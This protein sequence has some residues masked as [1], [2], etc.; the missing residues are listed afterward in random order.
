MAKNIKK[1]ACLLLTVSMVSTLFV[2]C[3]S[4]GGEKKQKAT[5]QAFDDSTPMELSYMYWEDQ[6]IVNS[7]VEGWNEKHA[8][9][10][11]SA[12]M[13]TTGEINSTIENLVSSNQVPD[14]FWVLGTPEN[15]IKKGLLL[16]MS[17]MWDLDEDAQN[18][19]GGVNDFGL[20]KF[21]TEGKWTTPVKFFPTTMF[22]NLTTFKNTGVDMPSQDWSWEDFEQVVEDNSGTF[23]GNKYF[24]ISEACTVIT[25]YPI[26]SDPDCIGEFGWNGESFDLTNWADGMEL[27][28]SFIQDEYVSPNV[29]GS[30]YGPAGS[31]ADDALL[32]KYYG[33]AIHTQDLGYAAIRVDQWWCWERFW[34]DTTWFDNNT[35]FVPYTVPHTED[36]A[37]STNMFATIDFGAIYSGTPH[38][39]ESYYLLKYMTWGADGWDWKLTHR[40]EIR[41]TAIEAGGGDENNTDGGEVINNCPITADADIWDRYEKMHP[42]AETGDPIEDKLKAAGFNGDERITAFEGFWEKVKGGKWTCYGSQQIPGF[43]TWL[44]GSYFKDE[45]VAGYEGIENGC[46]FGDGEPADFVDQ[47]NESANANADEFKQILKDMIQKTGQ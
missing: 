22:L 34:N 35:F 15:F 18:V 44:N 46:F 28:K 4:D 16:D 20:G 14:V 6:Y 39:L 21:G 27:E 11:L 29:G 42:H 2:G 40:D 12:T 10:K 23:S 3:G 47:L 8:N 33:S 41:A 30:K 13:S 37:D 38:P 36:N 24:G 9:A 26:A 31:G 32:T 5:L 43:D 19:I 25:L 1:L 7:L 45:F 17:G